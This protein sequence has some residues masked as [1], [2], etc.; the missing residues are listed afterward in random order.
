MLKIIGF[1]AIL[2]TVPM[3]LA[4]EQSRAPLPPPL[5]EDATPW[6]LGV[7]FE[8]PT[9]QFGLKP[10]NGSAS[11]DFQPN[12]VLSWGANLGYR[13]YRFDLTLPFPTSGDS[14]DK[15]GKTN[16][17]DLFLGHFEKSWGG[18]IFYQTYKG[19]YV[20]N[21]NTG[22]NNQTYPQRPDLSSH[23]YGLNLYYAFSPESFPMEALDAFGGTPEGVG[24]SIIAL[25]SV[26]QFYLG[27][28][29]ALLPDNGIQSATLTSEILGI[30]YAYRWAKYNH[31]LSGQIL[32]GA[33]PQQ[34]RVETLGVSENLDRI[35]EQ[36]TIDANY[37]YHLDLWRIGLS[38]TANTLVAEI[39]SV[40]SLTTT[41][42]SAKVF[43]SRSF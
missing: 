3:A 2:M 24:G 7:F 38:V 11:T 34:Q 40:D 29:H 5:A 42:F 16:H 41:S 32:V 27:G 9:L 31:Y 1:L 19:F 14:V 25:A 12:D 33:G 23:Y 36:A 43:G 6:S 28:D 20:S 37:T 13:D 21:A 17:L 10:K 35:G 22:S 18:D 8:V 15:K 26:N 39:G 30:G 4:Q